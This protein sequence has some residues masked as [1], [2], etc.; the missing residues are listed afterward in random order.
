M[1]GSLVS[2]DGKR[3]DAAGLLE[4]M[5]ACPKCHASA[6]MEDSSGYRCRSCGFR[7]VIEERIVMAQE[8]S[9]S[10]FDRHHATMQEGNSDPS[11]H[12]LCYERQIAW[13]Q[14]MIP[15]DAVVLDVGCGPKLVYRKRADWYVIGV[16]PSLD[17]LRVNK[18]IDVGIFGSAE[19]IPLRDATVDAILC[20]YSVHHMVGTTRQQAAR[21][22]TAAF[23]EFRRLL[24]PDGA[25][26]VF[27][28]S[29]WLPVWWLEKGIWNSA[30]KIL[31]DKLDMF[32][33]HHSAV[34]KLGRES[35]PDRQSVSVSFDSPLHTTFPPV[36]TLPWLR[37]PR[38]L[39]P[40]AFK[41]YAWK[42]QAAI[43]QKI[44]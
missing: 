19:S 32:F 13:A 17:S 24:K 38:L 1:Q 7:G 18:E 10:F 15:G 26:F 36:F 44:A 2:L 25:L 21:K 28:I 42:A 9:R 6:D 35:L 11:V 43:P 31:G 5:L 16:D 34:E 4:E 39:Y 14:S 20:F 30:R 8:A 33:W 22:V 37:I 12:N 41:G 3:D 27:D 23:G 40:L 29:P